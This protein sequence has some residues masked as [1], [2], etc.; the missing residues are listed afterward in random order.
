MSAVAENSRALNV[1]AG[2]KNGDAA[3]LAIAD[4]VVAVLQRLDAL[5]ELLAHDL[6]LREYEERMQCGNVRI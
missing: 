3:E 1:L 6:E 5:A 4:P 2:R